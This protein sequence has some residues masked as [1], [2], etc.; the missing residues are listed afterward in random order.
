M[1]NKDGNIYL[2]VNGDSDL[3]AIGY[4]YKKTSEGRIRDLQTGN[5]VKLTEVEFVHV[6]NVVKV[7]KMVKRHFGSKKIEGMWYD[8]GCNDVCNFRQICI[9]KEGLVKLLMN[10]PFFNKNCGKDINF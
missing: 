3:Y 6:D 1:D 7:A 9:E 5:S 8:L 2:I 10:N 4:T